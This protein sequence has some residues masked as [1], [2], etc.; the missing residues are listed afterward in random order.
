MN[1]HHQ[2]IS[3]DLSKILT[4]IDSKLTIKLDHFFKY[5]KEKMNMIISSIDS[6]SAQYN[7][8]QFNNTFTSNSN[9]TTR[10]SPKNLN[11]PHIQSPHVFSETNMNNPL[12]N[13]SM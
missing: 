5:F 13:I 6:M 12:N 4:E 3:K 1:K 2:K 8:S 10:Y 7:Q 9:F 11:L